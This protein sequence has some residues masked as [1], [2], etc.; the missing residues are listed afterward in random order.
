MARMNIYLPDELASAAKEADL[1]VS[2]L[3]QEAIRRAL[4]QSAL[5]AW[6]DSLPDHDDGPSTDAIIRAL[7]EARDEMG[8]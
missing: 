7:D 2:A 1:N 4:Q 5:A 3:A 6:F 8:L